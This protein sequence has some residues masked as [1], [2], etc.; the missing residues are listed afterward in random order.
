MTQTTRPSLSALVWARSLALQS[1][2][3]I[4]L[5]SRRISNRFSFFTN[6]IGFYLVRSALLYLIFG[7]I[8]LSAYGGLYRGFLLLDILV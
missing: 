8:S 5:F 2:L 3:F 4:N 6:L 7:F 1:A